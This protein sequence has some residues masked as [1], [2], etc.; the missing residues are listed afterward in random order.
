MARDALT[1]DSYER[2]AFA[3]LIHATSHGHRGSPIGKG[4]CLSGHVELRAR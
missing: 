2:I 4:H 3:P 1:L